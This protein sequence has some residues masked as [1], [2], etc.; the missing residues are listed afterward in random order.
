MK[1]VWRI[2]LSAAALACFALLLVNPVM[3]LL[4]LAAF[5]LGTRWQAQRGKKEEDA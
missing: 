2:T 1:V 4:T 3:G 5:V